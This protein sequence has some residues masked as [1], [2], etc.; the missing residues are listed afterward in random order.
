MGWLLLLL[1]LL[2]M[3]GNAVNSKGNGIGIRWEHLVVGSGG[4]G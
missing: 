1:L 3:Q 4:N 2:L